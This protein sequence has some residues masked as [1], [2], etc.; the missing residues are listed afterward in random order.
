DTLVLKS[1]IDLDP[2]S[3]RTF[4]H[5]IY[6]GI[7][8]LQV[9]AAFKRPQLSTAYTRTYRSVDAYADTNLSLWQPGT[10][11]ARSRT[12]ALYFS[13]RIEW[14]RLALNAG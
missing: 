6:A 3:T 14:R 2:L 11:R 12:A 13:D 7:D 4:T 1:R 5:N 8:V 10:V 9:D